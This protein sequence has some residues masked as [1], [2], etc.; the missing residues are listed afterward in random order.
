[1]DDLE[2]EHQDNLREEFIEGIDKKG[3]DLQIKLEEFIER[4]LEDVEEVVKQDLSNVLENG[5][6]SIQLGWTG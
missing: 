3:M 6:C 4:K 1:M 5:T 2:Y